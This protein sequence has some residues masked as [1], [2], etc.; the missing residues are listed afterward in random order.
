MDERNQGEK[1]D[2]RLTEDTILVHAGNE[3]DVSPPRGHTFPVVGIGASAGG[4]NAFTQLLKA[5]PSD[6]GMA[7]V[8]VQH[9]DPHHESQL[10]G[11]LATATSM[12]VRTVQD[13]MALQPDQVFVIPPNTT[14]IL[15]DGVLRLVHREPGLHLPIDAFF[16]SL[17]RVQGGRSIA[18]VLSGNASDGSLGVKAIKA[19]CGLTFAQD[20]ES[21]EHVGMPRNAI[22]TG[23]ID[24][25]LSPAE[26]AGELVN[27]SE[28][29]F[30]RPLRANRPEQEKLPD[31]NDELKKIFTVLRNATRVDFSH[32]KRNTIRRRIGR[33][34]I[35]T[36]S[37]NLAQYSE[38]LK[39][40]PAEVRELYRDLLISVTSFFRDPE[41]FEVLSRLLRDL[42]VTRNAGDPFRV[43]VPGCATGEEVYTLAICL[44]ELV[45]ELKLSTQ[46]QLFGTDISEIALDCARA[47]IY[48]ETISRDLST[49]RM[50]S[51]FLRVDRGFQVNKSIREGCVF[52]RQDVTN[53]PPFGHMDLISCRNL[54][55]YL[56]TPLQR[57]VLPVFHYSLNPTGLL[58]LG[59]AESITT[60]SDLFV[61]VDK[62]HRIYGR[63]LSP[64]RLTMNLAAAGSRVS[65]DPVEARTVLSSM[66]LQKK[67]DLVIQS[68]YAPA[69]VVVNSEMQILQFRGHTG[70]YLEPS[71]G[72]AKFHLLRMARESLGVPLRKALASAASQNISIRETGLFVEHRGERREINLEITP[73]AGA[74]PRERYFLVVFEEAIPKPEP[75][76]PAVPPPAVDS[77]VYVLQLE[78]QVR[79]AQQRIG[80]LRESLRNAHED[81]EAGSEELRAANEE[82]R[83][84]NEELQSTNEEL[85]TTKEELQSANEE[86]TT[87]NEE[88]QNRNQELNTLNNDLLNLLT[89]AD[90]PFLMVDN[91]LRLRRFSAAAEKAVNVK[92]IDVG[93]LLTQVDGKIDLG[94]MAQTIRDVIETLAV[95]QWELQDKAGCWYSTTIRPY[96]TVDNR[97]AGAVIIFVD[98]DPL[99]KTLR[100]TEE[101]RD[102][103]EGIIE[104]LREPLLVLNGDLRVQRAT[105]A[106]Y[107]TFR[108]SRNEV[109]GRLLYDMGNGQWNLPRLRELLGEAL[110]RDQPF[111]D[112]E[113][114]HAF[115]HIGHRTIRLNA[116]RI[117]RYNEHPRVLLAMED[118]TRRRE[119]AEVRYQ[120]LFETAKDGMLLFDAETDRLTDVNPYFLD[121]TG[122]RRDQLVGYRM[123]EMKTFE[124]AGAASAI[125]A[126]AKTHDVVRFEEVPLVTSSGSR[127]ES[128]LVANRYTVGGQQVVQVNLRDVTR[129]NQAIRNLRE[130]EERFR[131]FVESV[132]DYALFQ[133]D[134]DGRIASW[135]S[136]AERLLGYEEAEILGQPVALLF[137]PEDIAAGKPRQELEIASATGS[138]EDERWHV[139]KNG[140]RFFASGVVTTVRDEASRL[141]AFAKVMRDVTDRKHAEEQLRQQSQLLELAQDIILVRTLYGTI[142]FWNEAASEKYGWS[143]SEAVGQLSGQLLQSIYPEPLANIEAALLANGRWEGE[144]V[145]T[146]RDLTKL[147]VWSRWTL[148]LDSA[149]KPLS[150]LEI[151]SDITER[152]AADRQLRTSLREKEVLLKEI[153]HRVK[154]NLQ[155]ISS[156]LNLQGE[157]LA[158]PMARLVLE[159]MNHRVRSIAAIHGMLYASPDLS[160]IDFAGYLRII[161]TD[162][163]SLYSERISHVRVEVTSGPVFLD[164]TQAVPCGLIVNEL[165]TNGFKHAFPDSR[166]GVIKVSFG[167]S[168]SQCQLEVTDDGVSLPENIQPHTVSSMGLQLVHL[169]VEQLNGT[170]EL[171]RSGGT[172]FQIAF[173]QKPV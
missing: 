34:M 81:H 95:A 102:Y 164:I 10:T 23:A 94:K 13:G 7:F 173:A 139:R 47:G 62:H 124:D 72:E 134:L 16:V 26:I 70:F 151:N 29:P 22:A 92:A 53:D 19:E 8:L 111:Q 58:L 143:P 97:I 172:R 49:E 32:Y 17:A 135:N 42:L 163:A 50:R 33:R 24:Y 128:E 61:D 168:G 43:W 57:K 113:I 68:K 98:I 56:D 89:A 99:K 149:G 141:R 155:V 100:A 84:A 77:P 157:Y 46:V 144:V 96:R 90:I 54:L 52:A 148:Q 15:E 5:L 150:V 161:A 154:N 21:A 1:S 30:I 2:Q 88:L 25:V 37:R 127:L 170:L 119:A 76:S 11:I 153:H 171:Q 132:R 65:F 122:Y 106:F 67:A 79:E 105:S 6:T 138:A 12:P 66:E 166:P 103:A 93:H 133:V 115:P 75:E 167:V 130:S 118:I 27:L 73:I 85:S 158:D 162:L 31:G 60:A 44:R 4:L 123:P 82:V 125:V 126:D 59:S 112:F 69:A 36:R 159:E 145:H 38:L 104:T 74:S 3:T 101:A 169:L 146:T 55:I 131:L 18:I 40:Q 117:S 48:P 63:K 87:L 137:T 160:S 152:K 107:E 114:Q 91:D 142:S 165:L 78:A 45:D 121:L 64:V 51:F 41:T 120:R 14:M 83:S 109:E 28:H 140:S 39:E 110:F 156:L 129:R 116:R 20:E 71:P 147:T 80:E 9:L 136:G 86:L 35:V 108:V